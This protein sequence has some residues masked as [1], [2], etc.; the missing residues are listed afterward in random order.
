MVTP[1]E[2]PGCHHVYHQYTVRVP[3]AG[4]DSSQE[5][6]RLAAHLEQAGVQTAVHYPTPVHRQPLYLGLGYDDDLPVAERLGREVLS[7]PVHPALTPDDLA[8]IVSAVNRAPVAAG[9]A[10]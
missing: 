1:T 9:D 2:R 10:P 4:S 5:R 8:T 7:L 3:A 6:D